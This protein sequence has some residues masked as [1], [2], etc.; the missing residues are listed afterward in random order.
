[1]KQRKNYLILTL[2]IFE[3]KTF[4]VQETEMETR[5]RQYKKKW[6]KINLMVNFPIQHFTVA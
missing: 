5:R 6:I 4:M 3:P 2:T 1:M